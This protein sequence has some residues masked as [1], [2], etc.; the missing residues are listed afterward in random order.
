MFHREVATR[1]PYS[2]FTIVKRSGGE[3][4][5]WAPVPRLKYAQRWIFR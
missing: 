1:I 4:Q 5:I 3:R 2:H